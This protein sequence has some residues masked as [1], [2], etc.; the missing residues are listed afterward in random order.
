MPVDAAFEIVSSFT[1]AVPRKGKI[2]HRKSLGS[3]AAVAG[4]L[5]SQALISAGPSSAAAP[6][7]TKTKSAGN[8]VSASFEHEDGCT[9]TIVNVQGDTR[10]E[11]GLPDYVEVIQSDIC[12]GE[13][14][15]HVFK[16]SQNSPG[17][18]LVTS[19]DLSKATL[20]MS[21]SATNQVT[22][23]E[24]PFAVDVSFDATAEGFSSSTKGHFI[25][26]DP[27]FSGGDA[28]QAVS[29]QADAERPAV[30]RGSVTLG[31][32][33]F[34]GPGVESSASGASLFGAVI[35]SFA[36]KGHEIRRPQ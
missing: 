16:E 2:M 24:S 22:G 5:L 30:A 31:A 11:F 20:R 23:T 32:E 10:L 36:I 3:L 28:L 6:V 13:T 18:S 35:G 17:F 27:F 4:V 29:F 7:I 9:G 33:E 8:Y 1:H 25:G 19:G 15:V 34:L 14:L 21:G 12:L 26:E